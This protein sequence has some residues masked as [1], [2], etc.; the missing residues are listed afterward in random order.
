MARKVPNT[1]FSSLL[2][3]CTICRFEEESASL[4]TYVP[5]GRILPGISTGPLNVNIVRW[6]HSLAWAAGTNAKAPRPAN[7][8]IFVCSLLIY[9]LLSK[10]IWLLPYDCEEAIEEPNGDFSQAWQNMTCLQW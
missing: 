7:N 5:A 1:W 6:F 10:I 4:N 8:I 9:F 2:K 3:T